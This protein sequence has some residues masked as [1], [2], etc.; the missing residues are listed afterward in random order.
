MS[1]S[2]SKIQELRYNR[3][4]EITRW[5][6][7]SCLIFIFAGAALDK[8]LNFPQFANALSDYALVPSGY[9]PTV[10]IFLALFELW[11]AIGLAF[12]VWR[13]MAAGLTAATLLVY[14]AALLVNSYFGIL[15]PCGCWFSIA[16]RESTGLHVVFDL[17]LSGFAVTVWK[18][19]STKKGT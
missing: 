11:L 8:W 19:A 10:A 18:D 3:M 9:A 15:A 7:N 17:L 2:A 5:L 14:A 13:K 6:A 1:T 16:L 4:A 12:P